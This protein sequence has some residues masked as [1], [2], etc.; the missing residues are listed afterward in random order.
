MM[1]NY[2]DYTNILAIL[3]KH[4]LGQ[5]SLYLKRLD[6]VDLKVIEDLILLGLADLKKAMK[7]I[8]KFIV[9]LKNVS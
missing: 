2:Q 1:P 8:I 9:E 4:K 5:S 6:D 7:P 3:S